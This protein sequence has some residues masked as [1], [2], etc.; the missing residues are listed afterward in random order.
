MNFLSLRDVIT[1]PLNVAGD[2]TI[3]NSK[4]F[5]HLFFS[6]VISCRAVDN[7]EVDDTDVPLKELAWRVFQM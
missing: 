7:I 3:I 5:F 4:D 6:T 2:A 1:P